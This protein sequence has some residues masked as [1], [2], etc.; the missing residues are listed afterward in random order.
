M[1]P[2]LTAFCLIATL[3]A[4]TVVAKDKQ[5]EWQ[6]KALKAV[7]AEKTVIDARW[8]MAETNV[9]WVSMQ[10]DG[11][12]RDGFAQYLCILLMKAGAPEGDLKTVWIYD[13]ATF[14][15]GGKEIGIAACR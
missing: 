10:A 4:S 6:T 12:S 3:M 2:T 7:K 5:E 9:L 13:P 11:S 1:K 14:K 15:T 8:R